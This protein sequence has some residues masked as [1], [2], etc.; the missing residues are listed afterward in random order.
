METARRNPSIN[1]DEGNSNRG[2]IFTPP[3]SFFSSF[4]FSLS[5]FFSSVRCRQGRKIK[6][7][8]ANPVFAVMQ[9][10]SQSP[11]WPQTAGRHFRGFRDNASMVR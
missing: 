10:S 4:S 7:S 9:N 3:S 1:P 5:F 11:K 2:H 8:F 6:D